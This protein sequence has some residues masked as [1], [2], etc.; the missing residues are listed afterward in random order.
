MIVCGVNDL[1]I[2]FWCGFVVSYL[3]EIFL[4]DDELYCGYWNG[5]DRLI[6]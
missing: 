5:N 4:L 1:I 3:Y 6:G 2:K